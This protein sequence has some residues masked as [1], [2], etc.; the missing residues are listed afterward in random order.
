MKLSSLTLSSVT[1]LSLLSGILPRPEGK[2]E[3]E[4]LPMPK[5]KAADRDQWTSRKALFGQN[6]YIGW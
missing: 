2:F 1:F 4:S 5:V 6:D 3:D